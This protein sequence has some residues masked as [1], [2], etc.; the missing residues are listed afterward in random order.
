LILP[1]GTQFEIQHR[2]AGVMAFG[3]EKV[4]II[5]DLGN[6]LVAGVRMNGMGIAMGT[7]VGDR[8]AKMLT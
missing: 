6:G 1:E 3:N 8:L 2:W 4:P 7:E 5:Q